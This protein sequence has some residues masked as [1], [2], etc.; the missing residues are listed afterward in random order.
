MHVQVRQSGNLLQITPPLEEVLGPELTYQHRELLHG[1]SLSGAKRSVRISSIR[2]YTVKAGSLYA[3]AGLRKRVFDKLTAGGHSFSFTDLRPASPLTPDFD[4]LYRLMP[5]LDFRRGQA[6]VVSLIVG[7]DQ[8]QIVAP[9]GWGKSFV[10][11]VVSCIYPRANIIVTEPASALQKSMYKDL[12]KYTPDV[13]MVGGGVNKPARLTVVLSP[14][15]LKAPI[16]KCDILFV[17]ECHTA[18]APR[19]SEAFGRMRRPWKRFG[20]SATPFGRSDGASLV[21][22]AIAGPVLYWVSYAD[23]VADKSVV[24]MKVYMETLISCNVDTSDV[25]SRTSKKRRAY[26]RNSDRNQ[27]LAD[28]VTR[29]AEEN[30]LVD[31]QVLVI[32]ETF[33]HLV[34][35]L[36]AFPDYELV[37]ATSDAE[38]IAAYIKWGMLAPDF[39]PLKDRTREEMRQRFESGELRRVIATSTWGTG[40]N[41]VDLDI[42]VYASGAPGEI[43][44]TQ[45]NGRNSR[46][47]RGKDFG[48]VV[49]C[50]DKFDK[51]PRGRANERKKIYKAHGWEIIE[52]KP[53]G[54]YA[55]DRYG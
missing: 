12:L 44:V 49:D 8:G 52:R 33:E 23:A 32:A 29:I 9:T 34:Y 39:V 55:K 30:G 21:V 6:E 35:L 25:Q 41:F 28:A 22:E 11:R 42:L 38:D 20:F 18:G 53:Q 37:Y 10:I 31:P 15:L 2:L 45:W 14:S 46:T 40:V 5:D 43:P 36:R 54:N 13:G 47:R 16:D 24:P 4:N 48:I 51:W 27:L 19:A 7:N 26:W 50:N 1:R 3:A 17:D